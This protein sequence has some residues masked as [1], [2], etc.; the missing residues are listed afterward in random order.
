M[1][2]LCEPED[3]EGFMP[4]MRKEFEFKKL[5]QLMYTLT[6][7]SF[8]GKDVQRGN[9]NYVCNFAKC[10]FYFLKTRTFPTTGH[11]LLNRRDIHCIDNGLVL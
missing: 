7:F 4:F 2:D 3:D 8:F 11:M 1:N 9:I 6:F 10:I 5:A